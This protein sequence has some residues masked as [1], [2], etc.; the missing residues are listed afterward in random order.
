MNYVSADRFETYTGEFRYSRERDLPGL[1][2][3]ANIDKADPRFPNDLEALAREQLR[4]ALI[5][6]ALRVGRRTLND[7]SYI[8]RVDRCLEA[9]KRIRIDL[10]Q[11]EAMLNHTQAKETT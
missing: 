8:A 1:R 2:Q 10:L 7:R 11:H 6:F 9:E 3:L 5:I 4:S